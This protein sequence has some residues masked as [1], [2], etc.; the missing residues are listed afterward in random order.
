[1]K[2]NK[3][4]LLGAMLVAMLILSMA[5]VPMVSASSSNGSDKQIENQK[6]ASS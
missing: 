2:K 3:G 6:K 4:M 1:M 5:F